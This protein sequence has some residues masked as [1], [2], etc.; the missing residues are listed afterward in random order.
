MT[1]PEGWN[2]SKITEDYKYAIN[3]NK[4]YRYN[5]GTATYDSIYTFDSTYEGYELKISGNRIIASGIKKTHIVEKNT[6]SVQQSFFILQDSNTGVK[7]IKILAYSGLS[8]QGYFDIFASPK[9]TKLGLYYLPLTATS[10]A[11]IVLVGIDIDYQSSKTT[12]L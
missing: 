11:D 1:L 2:P 4:I 9:L 12:N 10:A 8:E 6:Y 7:E 5:E 3:G